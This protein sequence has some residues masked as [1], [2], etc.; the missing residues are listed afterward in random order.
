MFAFEALCY[1]PIG[2]RQSTDGEEDDDT[3]V[4]RNVT[5]RVPLIASPTLGL[6]IHLGGNLG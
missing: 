6:P 1:S 5:A 2:G 3:V 4:A